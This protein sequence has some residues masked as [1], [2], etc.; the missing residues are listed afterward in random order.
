MIATAQEEQAPVAYPPSH[1][2]GLAKERCDIA[3]EQLGLFGCGEVPTA[4]HRC[5]PAH[6][7]QA[8]GPLTGRYALIDEVTREDRDASWYF[9]E[10]VW[11]DPDSEAPVVVVEIVAHRR[12]DRL[13]DPIERHCRQQEIAGEP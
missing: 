11:S 9:D 4:R 3:G 13:G 8:F 12:C 7:V 6:V 5:P 10:L 2:D 1:L